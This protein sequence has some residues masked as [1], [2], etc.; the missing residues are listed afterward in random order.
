MTGGSYLNNDEY[1][2]FPRCSREGLINKN[3]G[4]GGDDATIYVGVDNGI[5]VERNT[6]TNGEL[7]IE[8]ESTDNTTVRSN[9]SRKTRPASS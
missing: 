6:L 7:G 1:G 2:I 3:S 8:L 5:T 4:G 9:T